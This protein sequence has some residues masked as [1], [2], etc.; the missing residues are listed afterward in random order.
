MIEA[1]EEKKDGGALLA[2]LWAS[3]R[4]DAFIHTH[5]LDVDCPNPDGEKLWLRAAKGGDYP[6]ATRKLIRAGGNI[7]VRDEQ[8]QE[9]LSIM[10]TRQHNKALSVMLDEL[11][12]PW[13]KKSGFRVQKPKPKAKSRSKLA[14]KIK[15]VM[16]AQDPKGYNALMKSV[17]ADNRLGTFLLTQRPLTINAQDSEGRTAL[18]Q[19]AQQGNIYAGLRMLRQEED[20]NLQDHQ[21]KTAL[22]H[23][24]SYDEQTKDWAVLQPGFL[25][26]TILSLKSRVPDFQIFTE[27]LLS[28]SSSGYNLQ[29]KQGRTALHYL[30]TSP[31]LD[32]P[33]GLRALNTL[34]KDGANPDIQDEQG[35]S[36]MMLFARHQFRN[37]KAQ[38]PFI[39]MLLNSPRQVNQTDKTGKTALAH[40]LESGNLA[41]ADQLIAIKGSRVDPIFLLPE[42]QANVLDPNKQDWEGYTALM[43]LSEL[44]SQAWEP[45]AWSGL[46]TIYG[47]R[48]PDHHHPFGAIAR[49]LIRC[50]ADLRKS[51]H[52]GDTALMI[53]ARTGNLPMV[54]ALSRQHNV[55][56]DWDRKGRSALQIAALFNQPE[57]VQELCLAGADINRND[58]FGK[59]ALQ[60]AQEQGHRDVIR[61]LKQLDGKH[62]RLGERLRLIS[63]ET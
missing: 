12:L 39:P 18:M 9:A 35:M 63:P 52:A 56:D 50:G 60:L 24:L 47:V 46:D 61:I 40:A 21:G 57:A 33:T 34:L 44:N 11:S 17:Q 30:L 14:W 1:L 43:L 28:A 22:M 3:P 6:N 49:S 5:K 45:S 23:W 32:T 53:A 7:R 19:A 25:K 41:F 31:N 10:A 42:E 8:G 58:I 36:P 54:W 51:N 13:E 37:P 27:K 59:T 48:N 26:Q 38:A 20:A 15:E 2:L 62:N 55:I 4:R 16:E 29:D